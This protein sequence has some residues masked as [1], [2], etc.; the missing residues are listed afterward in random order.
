MIRRSSLV[1]VLGWF[2]LVVILVPTIAFDLDYDQGIFQYFGW[3]ILH[4]LWPYRDVW[5][6]QLPAAML[7]HAAAMAAFGSSAAGLRLLDF[8]WQ[9]CTAG[10][11]LRC[12][13]RV[14]STAAGWWAAISYAIAYRATGAYHTAQR[15]SFLVLPLMLAA[16]SGLRFQQ[17]S[18]RRDLLLA[19][20][21][22]GIVPTFR[23]TYVVFPG[24]AAAL[25]LWRAWRLREGRRQA[26][27]DVVWFS[28]V[29]A[30]PLLAAI[31]V[32]VVAGKGDAFLD[33]VK[34]IATVYPRLERFERYR[35]LELAF[36]AV[37]ALV[38]VGVG[39]ACLTLSRGSR[40]LL[41]A[42]GLC[43]F[44]RL[45]EAKGFRYQ[46]WPLIAVLIPVAG[47][48]WALLAARLSG[49]MSDALVARRP[50][51]REAGLALLVFALGAQYLGGPH[52]G[53]RKLLAL[54]HQSVSA[55]DAALV[56]GD[57]NQGALAG[58]LRDHS[59][60]SDT[61]QLWGPMTGVLVAADRK[62]T[63][64]F[65]DPFLLFCEPQPGRRV[66]YTDCD[67]KQRA[68]IQDKFRAEIVESLTAHPPLYIVAHDE[69]GSLAI[70]DGAC[71]A[72][73]LPELRRILD[74]SYQ[75]EVTFGN[76][77][78]FRRKLPGVPRAPTVP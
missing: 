34:A 47:E 14:H 9:L 52:G 55:R 8:F 40:M 43:L 10:A 1:T 36:Q 41:V 17:T 38:W 19:A 12:G 67:P 27:L 48:G 69:G 15:D 35:V 5:D 32:F 6:T 49:S 33:L 62:S 53:F 73:D 75:R 65:T 54:R 18:R 66:L 11:F 42:A 23:P 63:T 16:S 77:S 72:P 24:V 44:V 51:L 76:W 22:L 60:V 30:L 74:T 28:L 13:K 3:G 59:S 7:L 37:P 58:Y 70:E 25:L 39:A 68:P 26:L 31:L 64:R 45:V 21:L 71:S 2:A 46:Y 4:G 57:V 50:W 29:A 20:F 56:G 78:A 61:I